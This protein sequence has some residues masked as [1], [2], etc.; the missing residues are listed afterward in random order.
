MRA[1]HSSLVLTLLSLVA[2]GEESKPTNIGANPVPAVK[3]TPKDHGAKTDLGTLEV[4]GRG[5]RPSGL[6]RATTVAAALST[7]HCLVVGR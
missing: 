7:A 4:A 6:L 3:N 1:I 2:C 5:I